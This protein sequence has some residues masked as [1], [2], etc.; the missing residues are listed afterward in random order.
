[1][2]RVLLVFVALAISC[3]VALWAYA[4]SGNMTASVIIGIAAML[5]DCIGYAEGKY[6]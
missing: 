5:C 2:L 4:L 1:M 3:G 6:A